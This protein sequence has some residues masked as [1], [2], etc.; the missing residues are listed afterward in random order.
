M[1]N[2]FPLLLQYTFFYYLCL[3]YS[4]NIFP[5]FPLLLQCTTFFH[6]FCNVQHFSTTFAMY[7]IFPLLLQCT[8]FFH[9][10]CNT[11]FPLLL[12]Y[13]TFS[14]TFAIYDIFHYFCNNCAVLRSILPTADNLKFNLF[15]TVSPMPLVLHIPRTTI[16]QDVQTRFGAVGLC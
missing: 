3:Q 16:S 12:Q 15:Y 6:Y 14:T 2:I 8:T 9:Y 13:T 7:N 10:F 11:H 1:Y 5:L 4:Y